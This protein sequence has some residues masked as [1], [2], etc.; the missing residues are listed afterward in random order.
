MFLLCIC[1]RR[2]SY[3]EKLGRT[4][5]TM[6]F[7]PNHPRM[8]G[9]RAVR[10][11]SRVVLKPTRFQSKQGVR[12]PHAHS[13]QSECLTQLI[14]LPKPGACQ[15]CIVRQCRSLSMSEILFQF[16]MAMDVLGPPPSNRVYAA[17]WYPFGDAVD[18]LLPSPAR[19]RS[20]PQPSRPKNRTRD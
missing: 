3:C 4:H 13:P 18:L 16:I 15:I 11:Y 9:R 1:T 12:G 14:A 19:E 5:F 7:P 8:S 20:R 6:F 2:R 17:S 10:I